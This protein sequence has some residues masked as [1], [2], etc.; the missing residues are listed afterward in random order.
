MDRSTA[1]RY[2]IVPT[3]DLDGRVFSLSEEGNWLLFT[4]TEEDE[5]LINS[6][7]TVNLSSPEDSLIDL[8]INNVIHYADWFPGSEEKFAYST[9]EPRLAAPGWQANNDLIIRIFSEN[10]WT[11]LVEIILS[12]KPIT[13]VFTGGGEQIFIFSLMVILR[14]MQAL[15]RSGSFH[16]KNQKNRSSWILF[17]FKPREIGLG[18]LD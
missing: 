3:G 13:V 17:L 6:L 4:R 7:W 18:C 11:S 8:G 5:D 15:I 2:L 9:V 10:G 14:L 16:M 12:R 1:N